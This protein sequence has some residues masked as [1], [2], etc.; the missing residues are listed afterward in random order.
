MGPEFG[1]YEGCIVIIKKALY[2]L[3]STGAAWN[4][5]LSEKLRAMQFVPSADPDMWM[6]K[7]TRH[8]GILYYEYLV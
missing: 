5:H 3:K 8:D 6:R 2:D 4:A 7:A 1:E